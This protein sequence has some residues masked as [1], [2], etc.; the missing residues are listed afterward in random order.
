MSLDNLGERLSCTLI[1][2]IIII[3]KLSVTKSI[4]K[5]V[6]NV[7]VIRIRTI[8]IA[9]I[10]NDNNNY[11][12]ASKW[13]NKWY[14][15]NINHIIINNSCNCRDNSLQTQ[16]LVM[17]IMAREKG[18]RCLGDTIGVTRAKVDRTRIKCVW[19]D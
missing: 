17:Q 1:I 10:S 18:D 8:I 2:I 5:K 16:S 12:N 7:T 13:C 14:N 11:N 6:W 19:Y 15:H 3:I 9:L 4:V